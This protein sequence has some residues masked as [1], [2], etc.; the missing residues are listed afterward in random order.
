MMGTFPRVKHQV[1]PNRKAIKMCE[2]KRVF[3]FHII[4]EFIIFK[5]FAY[6][7]KTSTSIRGTNPINMFAI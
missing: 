6:L 1:K 5:Y 4:D 3:M 2:N 7:E